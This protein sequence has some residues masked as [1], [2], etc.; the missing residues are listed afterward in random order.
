MFICKIAWI[1]LMEKVMESIFYK[2]LD[3]LK[4]FFKIKIKKNKL[5]IS[6]IVLKNQ[7]FSKNNF[8]DKFH[9][10]FPCNF[11]M[12]FCVFLFIS[13]NI[14]KNINNNYLCWYQ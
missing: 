5:Q 11:S 12:Q 14:I 4:L 6:K 1:F 3:F 13:Y 9:A 2:K 7:V 10:F 8:H